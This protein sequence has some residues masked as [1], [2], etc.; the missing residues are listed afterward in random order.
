MSEMFT[1]DRLG[2]PQSLRRSLVSTNIV[3][4]PNSGVRIRTRRVA[5]WQGG[6]MVIRWAAT[7]FVAAEKKFRRMMG[8]RDLWMLSAALGYEVETAEMVA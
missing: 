6:S 7:A 1:V 3:E 2:V 4:S 5:N 8:Y